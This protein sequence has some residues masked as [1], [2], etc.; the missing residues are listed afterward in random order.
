MSDPL[1]TVK[2]GTLRG[3]EI[4]SVLGR[5]FIAFRGI[6]YAAPPVGDLRFRDPQPA[7]P[8]IGIRDATE[9]GS[10]CAQ[11]SYLAKELI[12]GGDD[13]LYLNV[14]TTSLTESRP[15]MFLLHG[16]AFTLGDGGFALFSPDYLM[17]SSNIVFVSINYRLGILGFLNLDDEVAPG[18]MGLK[19]QVAAL[20]WVKENISRFGGDP[21]NVTIFGGSAG[22]ASVHYL[23]LSPL[24]KG[25]FHKGIVESG[26]VL[27]PWANIE[28]TV[29]HA[30]RLVSML[31][32][33]LTDPKEI[34]E[35]LRTVPHSEL[36]IAQ[37]KMLTD[38]DKNFLRY[39]FLPTID[40]KSIRPLV[41]T[42]SFEEFVNQGIDVPVI[43]GYA[44][45]EGIY[46]LRGMNE[47]EY[48][49]LDGDLESMVPKDLA[50]KSPSKVKEIARA[51]RNY[52]FGDEKITADLVDNFVQFSGDY[53]FVRGI[54][55][56]VDVQMKKKSPMYL[57]RFSY[58]SD[59]SLY[60]S[61]FGLQNTKGVT[62]AAEIEYL[63][64][65]T[66]FEEHIK[67]DL[68]SIETLMRRRFVRMWTDFA[69]TGNP[70]PIVDDLITVE[71]K[72]V[73]G[74]A[75]NYLDIGAEL[76]AGKN[77][78]EDM[79]TAWKRIEAIADDNQ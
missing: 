71:W 3:V 72:P 7:E 51:I 47:E 79:L 40:N 43:I 14:A 65:A 54:Q 26:V 59:S 64:H 42:D 56:V 27:N 11:E 41:H 33:D 32:R 10:K 77:L 38:G 23:L 50:R 13:C 29:S 58:S 15:V 39:H 44:S 53:Y 1:V 25:L 12:V 19:D 21:N 46:L 78:D 6:P 74:S 35:F 55:K 24:A 9:E 34:V 48:A 18:N 22:A 49:K 75:K 36:V 30:R 31:G 45:H 61:I 28:E 70:T 37:Q 16:G 57:Y 20:Q 8:W 52:Y 69:K 66:V 62:H 63:F 17:E 5:P 68:D 73:N 2:Q 76:V 4:Q 60:K 67:T